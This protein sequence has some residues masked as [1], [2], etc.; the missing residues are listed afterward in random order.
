MEG[1]QGWY[2]SHDGSVVT[3]FLASMY[4]GATNL[5]AVTTLRAVDFQGASEAERSA[6]QQQVFVF[7]ISLRLLTLELRVKQYSHI[8]FSILV[9]VYSFYKFE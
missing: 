6:L 9:K 1:W 5:G 2:S 8:F 3:T 4:D 7:F